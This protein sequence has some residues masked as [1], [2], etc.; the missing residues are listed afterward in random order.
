M[1]S[2][3]TKRNTGMQGLASNMRAT[4]RRGIYHIMTLLTAK[5]MYRQC[6][7]PINVNTL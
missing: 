2:Y 7:T 3:S 5:A 4:M 1:D 6:D